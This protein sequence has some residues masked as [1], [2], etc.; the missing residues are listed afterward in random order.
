MNEKNYSAPIDF[1]LNGIDYDKYDTHVY[2]KQSLTDER[3]I[4]KETV[5]LGGGCNYT[6][7]ML[8]A[9]IARYL[10]IPCLLAERI[11]SESMEGIDKIAETVSKYNDIL[12]D[13]I[14]P[15][16][17]NALYEVTCETVS[18]EKQVELLRM[19]EGRGV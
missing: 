14:V 10:N 19:P 11:L 15:T 5:D 3:V 18:E 7:Y 2:E 13:V 16:I 9:E 4:K 17:F 12:G 1:K 8:V 6:P